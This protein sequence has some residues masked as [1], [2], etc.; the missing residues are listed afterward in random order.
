ML[1]NTQS[2]EK[3]NFYKTTVLYCDPLFFTQK[4]NKFFVLARTVILVCVVCNFTKYV[5]VYVGQMIF[6]CIFSLPLP[7]FFFKL[8]NCGCTMDSV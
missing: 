5:C 4:Q 2:T 1:T 8:Y 6:C 3:F 7:P